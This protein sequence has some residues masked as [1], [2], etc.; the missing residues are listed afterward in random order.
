MTNDF[1]YNIAQSLGTASEDTFAKDWLRPEEEVAW[2]S[3]QK[4]E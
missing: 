2:E 4:S 3:Y 1:E